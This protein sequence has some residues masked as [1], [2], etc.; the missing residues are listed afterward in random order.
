MGQPELMFSWKDLR[1]FIRLSRPF[2]LLGGF[3]LYGLGASMLNYLGRPVDVPRYLLGQALVTFTQL[4]VHYLNEYYDMRDD[5]DNSSRSLLTGGSGA[6]GPGGLPRRTALY[7]A[8]VCV[9]IIGTIVSIALANDLLPILA[10]VILGISFL[11]AFFYSSPPLRLIAS[12]FGEISTSVVVAGLLPAFAF[13]V[14][15][16]DFH[17]LLIMSTTPLIAL[18]FA[19]LIAFE[20]P[21][22]ASDVRREKRTLTV[23][24]G[25]QKA[26]V[27]HNS[28]ILFAIASFV[29]AFLS[30]MPRRVA[31]GSLIA[32]PLAAAQIWQ[33]ERI[34]RGF[35]PRWNLLTLNALGLFALTAYLELI[36][37][38]L[39]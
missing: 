37:F 20:F 23:R 6:L 38:V 18:H 11:L 13:A 32:L 1:L 22:Y 12:G 24:L 26:M 10:W 16:G 31:L 3:L 15:S 28:A 36:G 25:W 5:M 33:M 4:M 17:R 9:L 7:A 14:Q 21:D 35:P 30:G 8:S 29:I 39:S 19:M 34:R 2:F 27:L